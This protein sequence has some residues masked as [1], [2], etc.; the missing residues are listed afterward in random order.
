MSSMKKET[1]VRFRLVVI[2]LNC[3]LA[4]LSLINL[5]TVASGAIEV[6]I[7]EE[8]DFAWT[9]DTSTDEATFLADFTVVNNGIYDITDLDIHAIVTTESGTLLVDYT[10][11]DLIIPAGEI[12]RFNIFAKMPFDRVDIDEWRN[13]MMNDSVFYLDVDITANYLWGL[14]EFVVDDTLAYDWE[15]PLGKMANN[16]D[17]TVLDLIRYIFTDDLD[18]D[19]F[20]DYV[21][22]KVNENP[23]LTAFDWNNA[24]LRVESWPAGYNTSRITAILTMDILGGRRTLTFEA[25]FILKWEDDDYEVKFED[26]NFQY[27]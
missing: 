2:A 18:L 11:N 27:R 1:V 21:A 24:E 19:G 12:K 9:V 14:G 13:L 23:I 20:V 17:D 10:Q 22:Q 16:T 26:F 7:P 3:L 15:A 5:Y 8:T 6:D 25:S 4:S